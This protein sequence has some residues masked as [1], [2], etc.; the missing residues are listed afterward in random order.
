MIALLL[1]SSLLSFY[2]N[3][4]PWVGI[5]F[6]TIT[7]MAS[8]L[9]LVAYVYFMFKDREALRSEK[10]SIQRLAIEKGLIGDSLYGLF[11]PRSSAHQNLLGEPTAGRK[12]GDNE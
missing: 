1:S 6:V 3:S 2:L 12:E 11:D 4:P 9:Y 5:V 10:Y 7:I 8:I